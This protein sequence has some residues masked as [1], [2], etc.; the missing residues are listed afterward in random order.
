MFELNRRNTVRRDGGH[1]T[2][3]YNGDPTFIYIAVP[4]LGTIPSGSY[5][6]IGAF[7]NNQIQ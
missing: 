7:E 3:F 6:S 2:A 4:Y 5:I 1:F